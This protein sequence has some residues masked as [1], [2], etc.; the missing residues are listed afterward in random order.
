MTDSAIRV[1]QITARVEAA[2]SGPWV[3]GYTGNDDY[4][5]GLYPQVLSLSHG[6]SIVEFD[7][8]NRS[9]NESAST[10]KKDAEFI[11][12]AREDIPW[13]LRQLAETERELAEL[14]DREDQLS[15]SA[16]TTGMPTSSHSLPDDAAQVKLDPKPWVDSEDSTPNSS[17]TA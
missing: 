8:G 17:A 4:D 9:L 10:W 7:Q 1:E 13:L 15:V 5:P 6:D 11:A 2:S 3:Y 16:D 12:A 14:R